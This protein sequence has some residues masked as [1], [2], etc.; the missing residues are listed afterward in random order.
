MRRILLLASVA[1]AV[2]STLTAWWLLAGAVAIFLAVEILAYRGRESLREVH[3]D[4]TS[5][6]VVISVATVIVV[7]R[8]GA[9]PFAVWEV[10][11]LLVVLHAAHFLRFVLRILVVRRWRSAARWENLDTPLTQPRCILGDAGAT[12]VTVP[13]WLTAPLFAAFHYL[14]SGYFW[15]GIACVAWSIVTVIPIAVTILH[16]R[17]MPA[18]STRLEVMLDALRSRA[19][20]ILVHFNGAE[21]SVYALEQWMR[22]LEQ[23]DERHRVAILIVD[24]QR[25]HNDTILSTRLPIIFIQGAE[26]I[27]RLVDEVPSLTIALYPRSTPPNKNL[28]RVPGL[29]DV[30]IN[31]GESDKSEPANPA[32]RAFDEIWAVGPAA[33]DRYLAANIG[34]REDQIRLVGRPQLS[35]LAAVTKRARALGQQR[36]CTV[37]Y[38]PT[39]EGLFADDG[40]SSILTMGEQLVSAFLARSE[41]TLVYAPHPALG[42]EDERLAK[43]S[44]RISAAIRRAGGAHR[45][46]TALDERYGALADADLLVTDISSDLVDF[47]ALDRPYFVTAPNA[48]GPTTDI[49]AEFVAS[50]PSARGGTVIGPLELGSVA[51]VVLDAVRADPL[52]DERRAVAD[53]YLGDRSPSPIEHFLARV[54]EC[55]ELVRVSPRPSVDNDSADRPTA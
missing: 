11:L 26:A 24:R 10:T 47:L 27:E 42:S 18:E 13:V 30:F 38:A 4:Q 12:T 22:V 43:A 44:A 35:Q 32:A 19:P 31:H 52:R 40:H 8:E 53:H 46:I 50:Y 33:R 3:A 17:R 2:V 1:C 6:S 36:G 34:V 21:A 25:W 15:V 16:N 45:T 20:E 9:S 7:F 39:W 29:F 28:L 51:Q 23:L 49:V 54:D 48:T 41:I 55:I 5:V 37:V 14:S